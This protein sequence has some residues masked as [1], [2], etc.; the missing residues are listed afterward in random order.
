M[1]RFC[2][3]TAML[4]I[5]VIG[6]SSSGLAQSGPG[7]V[8]T[9][10][11]S[12][13]GTDLNIYDSKSD[14]YVDGGPRHIGSAG[15]TP[16]NYYLMVT[17]PDG[18]T[19]LGKT[20]TASVVV[21]PTGSF[22]QCY[23]LAAIVYSG[24]STFTTLGYDDTPNQG[25]EFKVW[26]S[27]DPTFPNDKSKTDNFKVKNNDCTVDCGPQE[28]GVLIV[29]KYY[30]AN[31][32][33]HKDV[34]EQIINGWE[35]QIQDGVNFTRLTPINMILPAPHDYTVLE[36][37]PIQQNWFNTDP[38]FGSLQKTATVTTVGPTTESFG[39]VCVGA[40]GGLT[41]GFWSNKNGQAL[42][43][44]NDLTFL[45]DNLTLRNGDGSEF[46]PTTGAQVKSFV[47]GATAT[48]M[49]NMLSA[50]LIA[51]ELNVRHNFVSGSALIYAPGTTS[52]NP[53]G[54]ATVNAVMAEANTALFADGSAVSGD[55]NRSYQESLKNALDNANNNK[56]F[57]QSSP[58]LFS[59]PAN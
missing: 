26:V 55:L 10:D 8:F 17:E 25:G 34:G 5:A 43:N 39:N 49:S 48:N 3:F 12:C 32:N 29:E 31:A 36:V 59:F 53:L 54:F 33:G 2:L 40:G 28:A 38:G 42:I 57:V 47:L 56:N 1:K 20:L 18:V 14:V 44:A 6:F 46:N 27:M 4:A 35:F 58:C 51:M 9:T 41:I 13:N 30:D 21:D 19:V 45:K 24:S 37:M 50:Q 52:A 16:G 22:A 23:Q 7:A 11:I 15:L